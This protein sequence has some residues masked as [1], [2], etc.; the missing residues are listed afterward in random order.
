MEMR[1]YLV[2]GALALAV[3]MVSM[4]AATAGP[5]GTFSYEENGRAAA[6]ENAKLEQQAGKDLAVQTIVLQPGSEHLW[7][8]SD[9]L[10]LVK[11]G[12]LSA[13]LDCTQKQMWET[14]HAYRHQGQAL[15]KNEGQKPAELVAIVLNV[16]S[17]APAGTACAQAATVSPTDLGRGAAYTDATIDVEAGKQVVVQ[18]FVVEPGF[19]F[20][21]HQHPGPTMIVQ[22][23]GEIME[24]FNCTEKLVWEPGYV[25]H[26]TPG[27]HGHGKETAKN[28]GEE[29][30][31]F[32]VLFFNVWD[33]HPSPLVPRNV[34]PPY[35]ECPT[36]SL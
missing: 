6:H 10:L 2:S 4:S 18:S 9:A 7:P 21:W 34:E 36:M 31:V 28:E 14:G 29:T 17:E 23:R 22:L 30:A 33:W 8:T 15:L 27:H 1:R 3:V 26:H 20:W 35:E 32:M 12:T 5:R 19:N 25:Y 13:Y 16:S 11:Q 24:Y